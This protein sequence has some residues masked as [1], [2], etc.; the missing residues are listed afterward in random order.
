MERVSGLDQLL[1]ILLRTENIPIAGMLL[2]V[3]FFARIGLK[4]VRRRV[5]RQPVD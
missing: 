2:S 3:V 1:G 4:Q 5:E